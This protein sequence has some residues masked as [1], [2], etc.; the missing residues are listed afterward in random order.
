MNF[1]DICRTHLKIDEGVRSKLYKDSLGIWTIGVGRNLEEKGLSLDEID[2]LLNNDMAQAELD[3]RSLVQNFDDLSDNRKAALLN[4]SFNIGKTRL[5]G[6]K[7]MLA[8]V[9]SGDF[10]KVAQEMISSKWATQVGQRAVRL[11]QMMK[12]G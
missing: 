2:L 4:M 11:A 1:R 3:V 12:E 5:S 7:N 10:E 8:A 6:F 9:Q